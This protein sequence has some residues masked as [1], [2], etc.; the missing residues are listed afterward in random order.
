MHKVILVQPKNNA[1]ETTYAPLG[2][3]SLAAYI[4]SEFEVKIIDLRFTTTNELYQLIKDWQPLAVGFS[5]L[6]GSAITQIIEVSQFIKENYPEIKTIVGGIHPTFFPQ[7]TLANQ[8]LDFV[9]INEGEKVMLDLLKSLVGDQNFSNIN[10]LCWKDKNHEIHCNQLNDNFLNLN[11]LPMPAWD[12]I[13]VTRY[14]KNLSTNP[15]EYVIDFYTSKGCPFPCSFCYNLNFNKRQWRA[16]SAERAVAELEYLFNQYHI[17]YFIIHDDNFVVDRERALKFAELILAK[18]LKVKYS[19][20]A[21]VDF[22]DYNFLQTL[23]ESGLCELRVGCESGSNRLLKEIIDKQITVE[24]IIRAVEIAKSL[25][26][27]VLL[28]FVIAWPTETIKER[29]AT[30]NLILKLLSLHPGA[31]IYPLWIYI[32]YPGTTLFNKATELGFQAPE[33]LESW[34]NYFWSKAHL[35]WLN[36]PKEYELIHDLSPFAWYQRPWS[37][38]KNKSIKSTLKFVFIK[39]F[40]QFVLF[41]FKHNFWLFPYEVKLAINLKKFFAKIY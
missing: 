13:D 3:L 7:Q 37:G 8:Y 38:L 27:K 9:V 41:R 36:K 1:L 39:F 31:W 6:T 21:R 28:S 29:Q 12:L 26:L 20:D 30:I 15:G 10:N 34:G 24:Q 16:R 35:P 5:M 14:V 19:V 23:K 32:P 22:F 33:N 17:N 4:R 40:R 2:L 25:D 18:G 11:D